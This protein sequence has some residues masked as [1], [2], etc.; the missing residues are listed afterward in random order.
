MKMAELCRQYGTDGIMGLELGPSTRAVVINSWTAARD[1]LELRGAVYSSR[2]SFLAAREVLPPGDLHLAM[3][4]YGSKWRK[5][6]K[7]F[8]EFLKKS[9][10]DKRLPLQ[11]AESSQLSKSSH[12]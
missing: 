9:E 6:R 8:M 1:L 2:P 5:E 3:M 11:M 4:P 10:L 12:G 7:T